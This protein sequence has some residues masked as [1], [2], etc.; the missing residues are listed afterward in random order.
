MKELLLISKKTLSLVF[1]LVMTFSVVAV[2]AAAADEENQTVQEITQTAEQQVEVEKTTAEETKTSEVQVQIGADEQSIDTKLVAVPNLAAI[3]NDKTSYSVEYKSSKKG[4]TATKKLVN[5][6]EIIVNTDGGTWTYSKTSYIGT[7]AITVDGPVKLSD[8][9][10]SGFTFA[11]WEVVSS[12]G[13]NLSLKAVWNDKSTKAVE[14]TTKTTKN[15]DKKV[16]EKTTR[17]DVTKAVT[18]TK[19]ADSNPKTGDPN[20]TWAWVTM[21]V[22]AVIVGYAVVQ[23]I[24]KKKVDAQTF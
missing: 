1:A 5:G 3:K 12:S 18:T 20:V 2:N 6:S 8:P 11:G 17:A 23:V 7:T 4:E 21:S 22:S 16:E 14:K 19:K 10:K 13:K 15:Y 24:R 9:V